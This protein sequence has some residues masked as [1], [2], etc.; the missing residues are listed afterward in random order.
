[1]DRGRPGVIEHQDVV[2]CSY[3]G[4]K[5]QKRAWRRSMAISS[6]PTSG[7]FHVSLAE[8]HPGDPVF[9]FR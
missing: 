7:Q 3:V 9:A 5:G 8:N 4:S 2:Q 1:M 6:K